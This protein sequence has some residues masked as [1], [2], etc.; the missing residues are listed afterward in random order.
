MIEKVTLPNGVRIVAEE[1][2]WVRSVAVGIW[3]QVG[4][5]D[6]DANINGISHFL[7][8]M[9]FKGTK[10]RTA[11]QI[12]ESLDAVGGQLNAF[13]SKEYTCYYAKVLD[14]HGELAVDVLSD[15]FVNSLFAEQEVSKEKNVIVEEIKMYEDTPDDIVHDLF[16]SALLN[17]H[18]LGK[19][20]IG[21]KEVINSLNQ[22]TLVDFYQR[23][24][25]PG[26]TVI[27]I[28]GSA[29]I[30]NLII[31]LKTLFANWQGDKP[32]RKTITPVNK[33]TYIVR[34]KDIEQVHLCMGALGLPYNHKD[35]YVLHCMNSILGGGISS[36]LFQNIR[37]DR[38]LVYSVYSYTS[39]FQDTGQFTIYGGLSQQNLEEFLKLV[40]QELTKMAENGVSE[41]EL[42]RAREQLKGNL[43]LGLES[44]SSRMSRLGKSEIC[45]NKIYTPE[46][47]AEKINKVNQDE[48]KRLATKMLEQRAFTISSIGPAGTDEIINKCAGN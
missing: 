34:T 33:P 39:A 15:M 41:S 44:V 23:Y 5:R 24:Y 42:T 21:T 48:I 1:I 35:N 18:P 40:N 20:I 14:D 7:E 4:S 16:T 36:R 22:D 12:A 27:A 28:A 8:H 32:L 13:P 29:K 38:G 11:K 30:R 9:L 17:Q 3:V 46:E 37:E 19:R 25:V 47:I 10:N 43:F 6:E 26:N 45:L 2:P 31:Q